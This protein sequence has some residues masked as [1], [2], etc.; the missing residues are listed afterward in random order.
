M[1][2]HSATRLVYLSVMS[3]STFRGYVFSVNV[4][5]AVT[6]VVHGTR[7]SAAVTCK[8]PPNV[9]RSCLNEERR[10]ASRGS[11]LNLRYLS[12]TRGTNVARIISISFL[13]HSVYLSRHA[14]CP[15]WISAFSHYIWRNAELNYQ[16]RSNLMLCIEYVFFSFFFKYVKTRHRLIFSRAIFTLDW[17]HE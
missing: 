6:I 7:W 9:L 17:F 5:A 12:V 11:R 10:R 4:R 14:G 3:A 8:T 16:R 15:A 13:N 1:L 2:V